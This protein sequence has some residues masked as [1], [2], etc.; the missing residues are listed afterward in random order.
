MHIPQVTATHY[1]YD[2]VNLVLLPP[3]EV[4]PLNPARGSEE[5]CKLPQ[6]SWERSPSRNLVHLSLKI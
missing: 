3:L 4:G 1:S 5:R 6:R 2:K